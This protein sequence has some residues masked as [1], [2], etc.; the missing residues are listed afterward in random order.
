M[1]EKFVLHTRGS[2]DIWY[3]STFVEDDY[4]TNTAEP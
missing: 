4:N 1:L 3:S 2:A